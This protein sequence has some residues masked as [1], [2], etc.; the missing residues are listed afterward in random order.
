MNKPY[1][2]L[3]FQFKRAENN[4]FL[5]VNEG[6]DFLYLNEND[7]N[8]FIHYKLPSSSSIFGS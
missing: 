5:L 6:G 1:T 2:I 7:F 8:D 3:P 4:T